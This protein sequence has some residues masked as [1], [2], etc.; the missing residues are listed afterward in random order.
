VL[1]FR[2]ESFIEL[3]EM[4]LGMNRLKPGSQESRILEGKVLFQEGNTQEA[5]DLFQKLRKEGVDDTTVDFLFGILLKERNRKKEALILFKSAAEKEEACY[6]YW[7]RYGETLHLMGLPA[8]DAVLKAIELEPDNPW[9]SNLY[10]LI[11]I[12]EDRYEEAKVILKKA[13]DLEPDSVDILINYSTAAARVDGIEIALEL[14]L[15]KS[16]I[17]PVQ[18]QFGNLLYDSGD[19][20]R[21]VEAYRKAVAGDPENR[22]YRENLASA[23]IKQD[24]IL[25][26]EEIL[27][28]LMEEYPNSATLEMIA[29]VAFRKGEY[30]RA[31]I[32]FLE[33]VKLEPENYRILLNYGDFLYTRLDYSAA[34]EIASRVLSE[35]AKDEAAVGEV[36]KKDAEH[37]LSMVQ[38]ALNDTY[39]CS[40]CGREWMVPKNIAVINTV[41]LHGEPDGDSPAGKCKVCGKVY[42]VACAVDHIRNSRFV[43]PDCDE[44]LK[45][46][47]N[48]LKYLAMEYTD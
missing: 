4:I 10:G 13:L 2:D 1:F 17:P 23:F 5:F 12:S 9:A 25:G 8:E 34:G 46:S 30:R 44:Y 32:S 37:L 40:S 36:E 31:D 39:N 27:S 14:L 42:C 47:E 43:C 11:L 45:L 19:F 41:R 3:R 15:E 24:Y 29:Q 48:Y 33:A 21:A 28:S 35:Y 7:F 16:D 38:T 22:S 20:E 6:P 18:N 26:A